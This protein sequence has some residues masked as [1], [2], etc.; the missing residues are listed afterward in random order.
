MIVACL[1]WGSLIWSPRELPCRGVWQLDGPL[2]PIEFSRVSSG[3]LVTLVITE[4]S[5]QA[6]SLWIQMECTSL[7]ESVRA[8]AARER[9]PC[10]GTGELPTQVAYWSKD[11]G[12]R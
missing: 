3:G 2:L 7:E 5:P 11:D 8:L 9:I 4:G 6:R 12:A 10:P 1:G